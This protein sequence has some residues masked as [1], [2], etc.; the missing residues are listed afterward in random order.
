MAEP[1]A[2]EIRITL[3]DLKER[4][5]GYPDDMQISFGATLAGAILVFYRVKQRGP[6]HLQIELNE[7]Q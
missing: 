6:K 7:L 3:G 5:A 4:L 2:E 1:R